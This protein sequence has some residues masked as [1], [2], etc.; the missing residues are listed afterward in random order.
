MSFM[1]GRGKKPLFFSDLRKG[2][3]FSVCDLVKTESA[4]SPGVGGQGGVGSGF[5]DIVVGMIF[6][7]V[8]DICH[9]QRNEK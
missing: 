1:G 9:R 6:F 3:I 4:L 5:G 7:I 2:Y 8:C